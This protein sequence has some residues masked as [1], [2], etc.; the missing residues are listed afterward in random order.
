MLPWPRAAEK[1]QEQA[2]D[3]DMRERAFAKAER[4]KKAIERLLLENGLIVAPT[5]GPVH[6]YGGEEARQ[7]LHLICRALEEVVRQE[8]QLCDRLFDSWRGE[9]PAWAWELFLNLRHRSLVQRL[10][11]EGLM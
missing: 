5:N 10:L 7:K 11:A 1:A 2:N 8:E 3:D 6:T 9:A 4:T